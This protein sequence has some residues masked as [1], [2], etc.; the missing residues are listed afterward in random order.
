MRGPSVS[1]WQGGREG[2]AR[3]GK[4]RRE[5]DTIVLGIRG[6]EERKTRRERDDRRRG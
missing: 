5:G 1:A 4:D 6:K 3:Q 2:K